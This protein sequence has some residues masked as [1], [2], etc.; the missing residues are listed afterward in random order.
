[1]QHFELVCI[2][3]PDLTS[4]IQS[5]IN[6][7][8]EK[9]IN[10]FGGKVLNQEIWGLKDLSYTIK[11][12]KKGFYM[13]FQLDIDPKKISDI[14]NSLNLEE[15]IIRHLAIKVDKHEKLPTIMGQPKN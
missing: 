4:Q 2:L 10:G 11:K 7:N 13:L 3:K 12:N 1:M 8:L 5:K 6:S 14:N 15:N 9:S